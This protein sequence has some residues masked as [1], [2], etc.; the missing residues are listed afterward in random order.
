LCSVRGGRHEAD[1]RFTAHFIVLMSSQPNVFGGLIPT[2]SA[3]AVRFTRHIGVPPMEYLLGWRMSLAEDL[4]RH[5]EIDIA[6]VAERVGY[7]SASTFS[8]AF[9]R[10]VGQPPG[11][12]LKAARLYT[13]RPCG[14]SVCF[15]SALPR[16]S[17]P[18]PDSIPKPSGK[19]A[20]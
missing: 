5:H 19:S 15:S 17:R 2:E 7:G 14:R 20:Q 9:S 18:N 11:R 12:F 13:R 6:E 8:T 16:C 1:S 10:Y 4:L 3:S